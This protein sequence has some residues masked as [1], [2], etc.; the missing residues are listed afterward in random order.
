MNP[1]DFIPLCRPSVSETDIEAVAAVLRTGMLVQGEMVGRLEKK[2]QQRL[3]CK[4][5]I[6]VANGTASLH[7][8]LLALGIGPGDEVIVPAFS[9]VAT[10]NVV[11]LVGAKP[12][13]VDISLA[14][15]N[16]DAARIEAAITSA[17]KAIMPVHEFGHPAAMAQIAEIAKKSE[18]PIVEDA[19]CALGSLYQQQ[20]VG[21]FGRI[22]SF[23]LH[24]RKA[25]TSGEGGLIVTDDDELADFFRVMRNHGIGSHAGKSAFVA[26][27]FNY[28]MT[29]FQAALVLGQLDRLDA[30]IERRQQL[31]QIYRAGLNPDLFTL[32]DAAPDCRHSWQSYH[33]LLPESLDQA[34][35]IDYLRTNA[36]GASYG[37]QSIPI[38]H[39]YQS[40]YGYR[41]GDFA[42]ADRAFF[43]GVTLPLYDTMSDAQASR[44][45]D[46]LNRL[47]S[48]K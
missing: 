31:A 3:D 11:E 6:A 41:P 7:L 16:I 33:I 27:G 4:H 14:D 2:I 8:A 32:P 30:I 43:K 45:I 25:V 24:P 12:V 21:T 46:I 20:A 18:L 44:V 22:A 48:K 5:A 9:Y 23:S 17:T 19:A 40:R 15:F 37:A 39:Y 1:N 47:E 26:A 29:D 36:I 42:N 13:F 10:A 38:Q 35:T 34:E 28:R